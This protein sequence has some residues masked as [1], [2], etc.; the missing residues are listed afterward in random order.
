MV[1][2]RIYRTVRF[3]NKDGSIVDAKVVRS[4]DPYL[5]KRSSPCDEPF[6]ENGNQVAS[7]VNQFALNLQFL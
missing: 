1:S 7:V 3:V 5:D 6:A 2:G 4:V